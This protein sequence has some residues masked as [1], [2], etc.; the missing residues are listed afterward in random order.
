MILRFAQDDSSGLLRA[1][2][3]FALAV[4]FA[5]PLSASFHHF[6]AVPVSDTLASSLADIADQTM[7]EYPKLTLGN[8]SITLIN[9][10][11]DG[12]PVARASYRPENTF[13]PASVVKIFFL[14]AAHERIHQGRL[15]ITPELRRGLSDMIVHSGNDATSFIVDSISGVSSGPDLLKGVR[16]GGGRTSASGSTAISLPWAMTSRRAARLGRRIS[17][18]GRCN[19][20]ARTAKTATES[21]VSKWLR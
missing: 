7:S 11:T 14:V 4:I 6:A 9:L 21:P 16:S 17:T 3:V 19:C 5:F 13:H 8:F 10:G 20:S 15:E 1:A 12:K 18:V 2:V